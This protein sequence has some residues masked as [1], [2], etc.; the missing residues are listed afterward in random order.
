MLRNYLTITLRNII[1]YKGFSF[2]NIFGLALGLACC[3]LISLY[4]RDEI[5]YDKYH[6][7][8]NRI[9]RVTRNFLSKD[10]TVSLHLGH[11]APPFGPLLQNDFPDIEQSARI[12]QN[13]SLFKYGEKAFNEENVFIA[14]PSIF[15]IFTIPVISGDPQKALDE[16][17]SIML[18]DKMAEKY[19]NNENPIGKVLRANNQFDVK[20]TGVFKTFPS[21]SHFHPDFLLSFSTLNDDNI[22][23]RENLRT[24]FGNNSFGTYLLLPENYNTQRLTSQFPAF[25]DKHMAGDAPADAPKPST[26]TNLFLQKLTDIHLHSQLDSE[27]EPNSNITTVYILAAIAVFILIIA[28]I[29]FMNLS[30]ALATKRAKEVGIRKVMGVTKD[31]LIAQF[32][33]ESVVFAMIGL[34]LAIGIVHLALP[35]LNNFLDRDLTVGYFENWYTLPVLLGL[36]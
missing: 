10:G 3:L 7:N 25:L 11:A 22:Y 14:E 19:F 34:V 12:L 27:F 4:I 31:K 24:N 9:Y 21:N 23:G 35:A 2:I 26:W 18:S 1:K 30:T 6:E 15:K 8:A 28:C 36:A 33:S 5:S 13:G 16:P 32:L 17:F 29:N 20:V